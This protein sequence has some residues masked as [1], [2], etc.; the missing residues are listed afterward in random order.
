MK[1]YV[2]Q[3]IDTFQHCWN[4]CRIYD[5]KFHRSEPCMQK[6]LFWYFSGPGHS[7]FLNNISVKFID[8]ADLSG[9]Q[10]FWREI[11]VAIAPYGFNNENSA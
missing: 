6:H 8:K 2:R 10:N 9:P 5:R 7:S 4:N 1:Q 11:F 3:I